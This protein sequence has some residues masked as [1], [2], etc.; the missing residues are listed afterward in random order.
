M[1][2]IFMLLMFCL[3]LASPVCAADDMSLID[4]FGE[5]PK[6]ADPA[7]QPKEIRR[8]ET[9]AAKAAEAEKVKVDDE[10][11]FSFL[12]F[13]FLKSKEKAAE[14]TRQP[15]E[16]Q[17][18][19]LD[20]MTRLAEEGDVDACLTLGY[21]YLYGENGVARDPE[22]AFKYY[23]MAAAQEDKI[24]VNNLGSL[25]YS[26]IGTEKSVAKAVQMFDKAAKLG[27]GEA[28]IN[29]AFIYLTSSNVNSS[30]NRIVELL[31]QAADGG[32]ITAQYMIGYS[33]YRGFV[34]PKNFKKA[35]DLMK[36]AAVSYDEAQYEL[37]QRYI[38]AEGTPRNYGNAVKYLSEAAHQGNVK[39]MM[40]LGNILAA[41]TSYQ[42]NEYQA[43]IWFNIA[44]V[45]G[46]EGA[47][48]KRDILEKI[49]KIEEVLQA[50]A[51]AETFKE[52]P[53]EMTQ[54]IRQT[55]GREL[56][57]Y[58]DDKMGYRAPKKAPPAPLK[59]EPDP[60]QPLKLL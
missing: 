32:N 40:D 60:S 44:S 58:I 59:K 46:I 4:L 13:S 42:K 54:Y 51:A 47:A 5:E 3:L 24:A 17:E 22:R 36:M 43:Y 41:G 52:K 23:S 45:Y 35:F 57:S 29:L 14:F 12:N 38:N 34:V 39:A 19:F 25:Y 1:S 18:N 30:K 37:A 49:L 16:P 15:E 20:R 11:V 55:F 9:P 56:G 48:E 8:A 7:P 2:K 26:G 33:Y 21:M 50:Q 31:Q 28:A 10:G 53:T 27:N 6:K